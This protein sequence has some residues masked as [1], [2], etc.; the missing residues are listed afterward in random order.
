VPEAAAAASAIL[1]RLGCPGDHA[2]VKDAPLEEAPLYREETLTIMG[3]LADLVIDVRAILALLEEDDEE[4][5][6]EEP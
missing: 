5:D 3:T 1:R 6:E 2:A 4:E